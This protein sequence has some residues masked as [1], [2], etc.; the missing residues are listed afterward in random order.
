VASSGL[1]TVAD[2]YAKSAPANILRTAVLV[3]QNISTASFRQV[4]VKP[5]VYA[6]P[7][8]GAVSILMDMNNTTPLPSGSVRCKV[9]QTADGSGV[10]FVRLYVNDV[11]VTAVAVTNLTRKPETIRLS[12][13]ESNIARCYATFDQAAPDFV[14]TTPDISYALPSY[15]AA[16][17][18]VG[19]GLDSGASIGA[20]IV[21]FSFLHTLITT[22]NGSSIVYRVC[23]AP[24]IF[25]SAAM[26]LTL[27]PIG[28]IPVAGVAV[29]PGQYP[30]GCTI[31]SAWDDRLIWAG[32]PLFPHVVYMSKSGD[33]DNY[34]YANETEG[35]AFAYD[36]ARVAGA[37]Q[38]GDAITAIIPHSYDYCIF[39]GYRSF[40]IQRGDPT[41]G[42]SLDLISRDI[43]II[44]KHAWCYTP[45]QVILGLS[46][47]GLYLFQPDPNVVPIRVSRE[48]LPAELLDIATTTESTSSTSGF[49]V[50]LAYDVG[51][52]GVHIFV[53]PKTPGATTHWWFDWGKKAFLPES[54]L[55]DHEPTACCVHTVGGSESP[56]VI[57]G[58]RDGYLRMAQ[59]TASTDDGQAIS[60]S[61][62]LGP[63]QLGSPTMHGLLHRIWVEFARQSGSVLVDILIA[64]TPERARYALPAMSFSIFANSDQS[65]VPTVEIVRLRGGA[66]FIRLTGSG[67]LA[68]ALESMALEREVVGMRR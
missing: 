40:S 18:R 45:E 19:F 22:T 57:F 58:C 43:G 48:R 53:T 1:P 34:L 4:S 49:D 20:A 38:I 44:D 11:E 6:I 29:S 24:K 23:R 42:G 31:V 15:T 60:S 5:S 63:F 37:S 13:D 62:L 36:P 10:Y 8:D 30:L 56:R 41:I 27:V 32:D 17:G 35:E 21:S 66:C 68:W 25:D 9:G 67:I 52:Q 50:Q 26:T 61:A 54:Y 65:V 3:D 51:K 46:R 64:D 55:P 47:D 33:P 7:Y 16:G 14:S 2:G 59:N 28:G 39:A 12:I